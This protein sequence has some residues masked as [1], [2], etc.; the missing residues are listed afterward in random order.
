MGRPKPKTSTIRNRKFI[1]KSKSTGNF[2]VFKSKKTGRGKTRRDHITDTQ[3]VQ[4]LRGRKPKLTDRK[5][6]IT[7]LSVKVRNARPKFVEN[8]NE[9]ARNDAEATSSS[10]C[11]CELCERLAGAN[12]DN[13]YDTEEELAE[14]VAKVERALPSSPRMRKAVIMELFRSLDEETQQE[15]IAN[16]TAEKLHE[17]HR[18]YHRDDISRLSPANEPTTVVDGSTDQTEPVRQLVC[19][20]KQAYALY[21]SENNGTNITLAKFCSLRPPH[22]TL[23]SNQ[24]GVRMLQMDLNTQ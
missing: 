24:K 5:P 4:G 12:I 22:I 6:K 2:V 9:A 10:Y 7:S 21:I 17:I 20:L 18:F 11:T 8:R 19:T 14:A 13:P 15:I 3:W 1:N 16:W 23:S